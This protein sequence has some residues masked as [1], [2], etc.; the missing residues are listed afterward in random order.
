MGIIWRYS[1]DATILMDMKVFIHGGTPII[2]MVGLSWKMLWTWMIWGSP[3]SGKLQLAMFDWE[4]V[5]QKHPLHRMGSV[6][7]FIYESCPNW[8]VG[9]FP[10]IRDPLSDITIGSQMKNDR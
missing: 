10:K 2:E 9:G 5:Q 3:T 6:K 4:K 8:S 7:K 1:G